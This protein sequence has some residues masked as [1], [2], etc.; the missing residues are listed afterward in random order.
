MNSQRGADIKASQTRS[1]NHLVHFKT[2]HGKCFHK[3]SQIKSRINFDQQSG[4]STPNHIKVR[5]CKEGIIS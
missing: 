3:S 4:R 1:L 5:R 2:P